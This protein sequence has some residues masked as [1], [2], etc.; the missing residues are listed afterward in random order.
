VIRAAY[1]MVHD[2]PPMFHHFPTSTMPPW[3]ARVVLN[4]VPF[5]DPYGAYAGGNPFLT[6]ESLQGR[7]TAAVF[8]VGSVYATQQPTRSRR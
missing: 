4:N 6:V 2:Q 8:P 3:G 1:G 5:S 7:S